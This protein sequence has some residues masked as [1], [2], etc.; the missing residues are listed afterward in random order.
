MSTTTKTK[1]KI[2]TEKPPF[3]LYTPVCMSTNDIAAVTSYFPDVL[4]K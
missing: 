1:K 4:K 3:P 2:K